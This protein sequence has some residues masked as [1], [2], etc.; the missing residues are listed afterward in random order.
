M[1]GWGIKL[2]SRIFFQISHFEFSSSPA[3]SETKFAFFDVRAPSQNWYVLMPKE[4]IKKF[5][6]APIKKIDGRETAVVN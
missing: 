5:D 6:K 3:S 4:P 1:T 2:F